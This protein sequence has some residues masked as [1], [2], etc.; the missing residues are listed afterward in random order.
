MMLDCGK[1]K[2]NAITTSKINQMYFSIKIMWWMYSA[3]EK[4][5]LDEAIKNQTRIQLTEIMVYFYTTPH[6][7]VE[8]NQLPMSID[9][10]Y[11]DCFSGNRFFDQASKSI[12]ISCR[13]FTTMLDVAM[14]HPGEFTKKK[15]INTNRKYTM[16]PAAAQEKIN[17]RLEA[18][19]IGLRIVSQQ[20]RDSM[21]NLIYNTSEYH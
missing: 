7:S 17:E 11:P 20:C 6:F 8:Y 14:V 2:T 15:V 1:K 5:T 19:S 13:L 10:W 21:D 12:I 16:K 4:I 9:I 18:V 3:F